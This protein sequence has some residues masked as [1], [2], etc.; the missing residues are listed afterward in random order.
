MVRKTTQTVVPL[1][2]AVHVT[3]MHHFCVFR[4]ILG[5]LEDTQFL[6]CVVEGWEWRSRREFHSQV[7]RGRLVQWSYTSNT[8]TRVSNNN[9]TTT[10]TRTATTNEHASHITKSEGGQGRGGGGPR[11]VRCPSGTETTS[12]AEA[13]GTSV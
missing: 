12:S 6:L 7:T 11:G 10:T 3:H 1:L 5:A 2:S 13:A 8:L 4:V 9:T